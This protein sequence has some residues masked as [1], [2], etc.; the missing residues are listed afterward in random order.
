MA[1]K[2]SETLDAALEAAINPQILENLDILKALG[3]DT[4]LFE[5]FNSRVLEL[6]EKNPEAHDII[7]GEL[8]KTHLTVEGMMEQFEGEFRSILEWAANDEDYVQS[9][10]FITRP[11]ESPS[12]ISANDEGMDDQQAA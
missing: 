12:Y 11:L 5:Q 4:E 7:T 8:A 6:V 9:H 2:K 3:V 10:G 1:H